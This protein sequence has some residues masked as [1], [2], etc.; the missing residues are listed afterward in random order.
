MKA[1]TK[2]KSAK[3]AKSAPEQG[4]VVRVEGDFYPAIEPRVTGIRGIR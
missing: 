1:V 2:A 4:D 3:S